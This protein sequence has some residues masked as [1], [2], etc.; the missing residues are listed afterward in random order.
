MPVA[1][2]FEAPDG[3]IF[4]NKLLLAS[5]VSIVPPTL[6]VNAPVM[7]K[8]LVPRLNPCA[9][10][11]PVTAA[12]PPTTL[13]CFSP[14][15]PPIAPVTLLPPL[16]VKVPVF[17]VLVVMA[18]VSVRP[19]ARLIKPSHA[20]TGAEVTLPL[21]LIV[22]VPLTL[23]V[24]AKTSPLK[25]TV[26]PVAPALKLRNRIKLVPVNPVTVEFPRNTR[27]AVLL[28]LLVNAPPRSLSVLMFWLLPMVNVPG[29]V[30]STPFNTPSPPLRLE[31]LPPR[32][33]SSSA[34]KLL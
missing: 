20:K 15:A 32:G 24:V 28:A 7:V 6:V 13:I 25:L 3:W 30:V 8:V 26:E 33:P 17:A 12:F 29:P 1:L 18:P 9:C 4:P 19:A 34:P 10:T 11:A 5:V 14:L 16:S 27:L 21:K 23:E 2:I 22:P 31:V